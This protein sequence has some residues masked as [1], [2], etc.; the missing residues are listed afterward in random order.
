MSESD[1]QNQETKKVSKQQKALATKNPFSAES[2][3]A[4]AK[5]IILMAR[6]TEFLV[7]GVANLDG[8]HE[9]EQ[10][11]VPR[12]VF[13]ALAE[14]IIAACPKTSFMLIAVGPADK[15][16][17]C[18]SVFVHS[19]SPRL[20]AADWLIACNMSDAEFGDSTRAFGYSNSEYP[21]KQKDIVSGAAFAFLRKMKL[22]DEHDS[23]DERPDFDINAD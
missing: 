21:I 15:E 4:E 3:A 22:L 11:D 18:C 16:P 20:S 10:N 12:T 1:N 6:E 13:E 2:I 8:T 19:A 14:Q 9:K 23:D 7:T 17:K 5:G